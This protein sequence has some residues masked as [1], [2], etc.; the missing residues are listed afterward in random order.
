M[1]EA[2]LSTEKKNNSSSCSSWTRD[3]EEVGDIIF[4]KETR[5]GRSSGEK[6]RK[7]LLTLTSVVCV[8]MCVSLCVLCVCVCVCVCFAVY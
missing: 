3:L 7:T 2:I 8:S 1:R 6:E 5:I 4:Q